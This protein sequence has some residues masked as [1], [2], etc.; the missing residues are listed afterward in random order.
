MHIR[1][2]PHTTPT[3]VSSVP[4]RADL[5]VL[6]IRAHRERTALTLALAKAARILEGRTG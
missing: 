1:S 3:D 5:A 2:V 6:R 4:H